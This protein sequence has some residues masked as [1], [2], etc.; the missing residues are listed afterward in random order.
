MRF[1][2][3]DATRTV[4]PMAS[5]DTHHH[6]GDPL[7]ADDHD[8]FGGRARD[9]VMD[10]RRAL[11]LFAGAGA[12]VALLAACGGS[13]S[14]TTTSTAAP[15]TTGATTASTTAAAGV[16]ATTAAAGTTDEVAC[17]S[18]IPDETGGPF[19]GDG[20]NGPD[21]LGMDGVVRQDI[22]TSIGGASGTA[23]GL[24]LTLTFQVLDTS[25]GCAPLAGAAVYAWHCTAD[26]N[27]SMY[28]DS[29]AD[30]NFLRGVQVADADGLLTF[31]TVF[32]GCYPGRWP[33]VHFEVYPTVDDAIAASNGVKTSQ[34]AFPQDACED[35]YTAQGYEASVGNLAQLS[36]DTDG[37]FADGWENQLATMTGDASAGM[38]ATLVVRV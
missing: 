15:G 18:P 28:S 34:L 24:P 29:V 12:G 11:R 35:A 6:I 1:T 32:P 30:E 5:P 23:E 14:T 13:D 17:E 25:N 3:A 22:R 37:V 31:T 2:A 36:I 33:H 19:P 9:I 38:T 16:T 27:Y 26:G 8:D 4:G 20:S 10:R 21:V 7:H